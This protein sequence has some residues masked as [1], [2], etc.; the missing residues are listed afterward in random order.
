ML[1]NP[2]PLS[3]QA[4]CN[5]N[6]L[7]PLHVLI[8]AYRIPHLTRVALK[9]TRK[10]ACTKDFDFSRTKHDIDLALPRLTFFPS[11]FPRLSLLRKRQ[12]RPT[13]L[14]S[15]I[16]AYYNPVFTFKS[17]KLHPT[18][19]TIP[20]EIMTKWSLSGLFGLSHF[21]GTTSLLFW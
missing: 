6:V 2:T 21:L 8:V 13:F 9:R 1:L 4:F 11:H 15:H 18:I 7:K 3:P 5:A 19:Q 12:V 10:Q 14:P 17:A 16:S 20:N